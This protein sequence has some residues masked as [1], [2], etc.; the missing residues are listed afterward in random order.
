MKTQAVILLSREAD[1]EIREID[2]EEPQPNEVLVEMV[3]CGLC[4]TDLLVK[5]PFLP[6]RYPS[7]IGH[8][9]AGVVKKVGA[10]VTRVKEGDSVILS[11][12][13]CQQCGPCNISRPAACPDWVNK[14]FLRERNSTI[15][16]AP[17]YKLASQEN[18]AAETEVYGAFFGQSSM[19]RMS[20]V[21]ESS[22]V[23]VPKDL[24]LRLRNHS[25]GYRSGAIFNTL[26]PSQDSTL[27]VFGCGAVGMAAILAAKHLGVQTIIAVDLVQSRLDLA[28]EFGATHAVMGSDQDVLDQI[29]SHTK[30]KL[31][32]THA[33]EAT[34]VLPV[35]KT[36]FDSL[37]SFGHLASIGNPGVGITPPFEINDVVNG[38]KTWSGIIMGGGDP[39]QA[40]PFLIE[41]H[42]EGRFPLEKMS[43][44]YAFDDFDKAM[45]DMHDGTTIK[46]IIV[47]K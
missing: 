14:N 8:E 22:C 46:P 39:R 4:H 12:A 38:G 42:R 13:S 5:G 7:T 25:L 24:D 47:F 3:A 15:G 40:L 16:H 19:A 28:R 32:V 23:K 37:A 43:R 6:G 41:L 10:D 31:G 27:A 44:Y 18:N 2:I 21:S 35:L 9:G 11:F 29:R 36:A 30:W 45:H 20:L 33:V 26:K 17:A 34:G 1:F